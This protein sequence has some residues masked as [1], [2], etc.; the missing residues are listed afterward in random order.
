MVIKKGLVIAL[1]PDKY[2]NDVYIFEIFTFFVDSFCLINDHDI[3]YT[4]PDLL[5]KMISSGRA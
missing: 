2:F 3:S 4:I 5:F 1:F